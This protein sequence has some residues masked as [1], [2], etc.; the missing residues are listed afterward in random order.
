MKLFELIYPILKSNFLQEM[1][2]YDIR[3]INLIVIYK[4]KEFLVSTY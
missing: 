2:L 4:K 3:K 1:D